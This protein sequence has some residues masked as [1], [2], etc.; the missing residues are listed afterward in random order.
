MSVEFELI[1]LNRNPSPVISIV[2]LSYNNSAY[3]EACLDHVFN[4]TFQNF[5]VIAVDNNSSDNSLELFKKYPITIVAN[6]ENVGA[7]IADNMG[8]E[9]ASGKYLLILDTDTRIE[10]NALELLHAYMEADDNKHVGAVMGKLMLG[11]TSTL[12]SAG[13]AMNVLGHTWCVGLNEIDENQYPSRL[14]NSISG[15]CFF[16]RKS[17]IDKIGGY[18]PDMF[19]YNED[20]D[21]S[22]RFLLYGYKLAYLKDAVV[23]HHYSVT[24]NTTTKY[25]Y[26]ERN[27]WIIL[28]KNFELKTLLLMLP[29]LIFQ[30]LGILLFAIKR[31]FFINKISGYRWILQQLP[32]TLRKRQKIQQERVVPD[33]DILPLL[34]I[35]FDYADCQNFLVRRV[36]NPI[37][38]AHSLV[39]FFLLGIRSRKSLNK[40]VA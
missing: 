37:S 11:T 20:A 35:Q 14:V 21:L 12:N 24:V 22:L 13:N 1:D 40:P 9:R 23:Q 25:S 26:L 34:E 16:A 4:Q 7:C 32:N 5:E 17:I 15:A 29:L 19:L 8:M 38:K 6:K 18:D 36:L 27:R 3:I 33:R 39:V 10:K 30:E 2:I 31:G 28:L